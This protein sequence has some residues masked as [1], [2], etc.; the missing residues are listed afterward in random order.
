AA[1]IPELVG[2]VEAGARLD[3]PAP[4]GAAVIEIV[5]RP[6]AAAG[7]VFEKDP[8]SGVGLD[9]VVARAASEEPGALPL[10]SVLL[11]ALYRRDVAE[12]GGRALTF[13]SYRALGE[14]KGAI[15]RR[16][17][18]ALAELRARDPEAAAALPAVLRALVTA[19]GDGTA[20]ARP[21]RLDAFPE[22]GPE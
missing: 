13:A 12:G 10:L 21:A 17:D 9:A 8:E 20:T 1:E 19:S 5:R 6:A 16:A 7:I 4:D 11:Q 14:L 15:A 2:L 22:N 18:E 3:L